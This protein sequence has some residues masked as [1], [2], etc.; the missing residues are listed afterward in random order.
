M[1]IR[2][3]VLPFKYH[4]FQ[5]PFVCFQECSVKLTTG[6]MFIHYVSTAAKGMPNKSNPSTDFRVHDFDIPYP[7][8]FTRL[9]YTIHLYL[10][11][12]QIPSTLERNSC[13]DSQHVPLK[14]KNQNHQLRF[15]CY[16]LIPSPTCFQIWQMGFT[17]MRQGCVSHAARAFD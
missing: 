6:R 16:S 2:N 3:M 15:A 14:L 1:D 8:P 17:C 5:V 12:I 11:T 10:A 9:V 13:F 7:I 4:Q